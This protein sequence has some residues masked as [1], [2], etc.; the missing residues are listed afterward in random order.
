ML[1][2]KKMLTKMLTGFRGCDETRVE[3]FGTNTLVTPTHDGWL[4]ASAKSNSNTGA[5]PVL[6]IGTSG[7]TIFGEGMG[8]VGIGN[9]FNC[10][11]PVKAGIEYTISN[12]RCNMYITQNYY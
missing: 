6:R 5:A 11:C 3:S 10:A 8:I 12:Y 2:T 9:V 4:V 1:N 7:G